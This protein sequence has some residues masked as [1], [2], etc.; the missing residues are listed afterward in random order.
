M[1]LASYI[2]MQVT[3]FRLLKRSDI[4]G[5]IGLLARNRREG[6]TGVLRLLD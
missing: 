1:I 2:L 4:F 5:S 3:G 6:K